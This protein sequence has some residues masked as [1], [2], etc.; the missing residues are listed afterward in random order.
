[1][2]EGAGLLL[3][4]QPYFKTENEK[5]MEWIS[6]KDRLP[7]ANVLV[8]TKIEDASGT[9]NVQTMRRNGNLWFSGGVYVYYTPT[10]WMPIP[11]GK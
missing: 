2:V 10:H 8:K 5:R 3:H 6:V 9:R 7:D 11:D 4:Y 1:L